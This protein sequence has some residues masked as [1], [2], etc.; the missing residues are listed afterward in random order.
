MDATIGIPPAVTEETARFWAAAAEGRLVVEHCPACG[1]DS[2]P[3]RGICRSCRSRSLAWVE[4]TGPGRVYSYTVNHQRWL[5]DLE[6]PYAVVLVEFD[7]HPGVRVPGRLR[8]CEPDAV[9][10]GLPVT[11]AFEP[12]P[13][14]QAIPSFVAAPADVAVGTAGA[15]APP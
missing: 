14:G 15:G 8:G 1:A 3:P 10:V 4:I 7:A 12:G 9:T 13:G 11:I 5:P 6:V 2:F